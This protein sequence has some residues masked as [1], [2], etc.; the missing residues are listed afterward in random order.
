MAD[1]TIRVLLADDHRIFRDGIASMFRG[2]EEITI[3]GM[4]SNG[5]EVLGMLEAIKPEVIILDISMPVMGGFELLKRIRNIENRPQ[6]LIL[7]MY[8]DIAYVTEAL[9]AGANG[10]VCKEDTSKDELTEAVTSIISGETYFGKSVKQ[11]LEKQFVAGA[12]SVEKPNGAQPGPEV[13]SKRETEVL[14]MVMEGLSNQEIADATY[15]SIRTVETHKTNIMTKLN[16]KNTVE[17]VKYVIK[18]KFFEI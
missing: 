6:V 16:L 1:K 14:R 13:L 2:S 17:L 18:H 15:V 11:Q 10:Y 4:A 5:V 3:A 9:A 12:T 8:S 7:S